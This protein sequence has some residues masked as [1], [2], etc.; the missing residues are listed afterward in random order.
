MLRSDAP[1]AL[2]VDDVPLNRRI[3]ANLLAF[4]GVVADEADHADGA[5]QALA[6]THYDL[7]LLDI[8]LG[9]RARSGWDV[10][11]V[12]SAAKDGPQV[13]MVTGAACDAR[14]VARGLRRGARD[15]LTRPVAA[16]ILR[17]RVAAALRT[18]SEA[19]ERA[20]DG[21]ETPSAPLVRKTARLRTSGAVLPHGA[22]GGDAC[23]IV[24][25]VSGRTS[26]VLVDAAGHG[27]S[28]TPYA[29]SAL[30][31]ASALL[32]T[33]VALDE[34]C[35]AVETTLA[36]VDG[37]RSCVAMGIARIDEEEVEILNAGLPPI[38]LVDRFAVEL[39]SPQAP[40]IGL[41]DY[42]QVE[43]VTLPFSGSAL[44]AMMTDGVVNGAL[45]G[46]A[47]EQA[48]DR[49]GAVRHGAL[50]ASATAAQV[51][52][53]IRESQPNVLASLQD[54]ACVVFA[55][56]RSEGRRR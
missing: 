21:L 14:D 40:P 18:R 37:A 56:R 46:H 1:R 13:I 4:E 2:V 9:V 51:A 42:A 35:R 47:V 6:N 24:T 26:I 15:Y 3:L 36:R 22:N 10:L 5:L 45:D 17:A 44:L 54:D 34:V 29:W 55:S 12:I 30:A 53:L 19:P 25:D 48:L 43:S 38:A 52:A 23:D 31:V 20:A 11:E 32:R 49:M 41:F 39:V 27:P 8:D 16:D 33:G 28:A 7:V 50:L